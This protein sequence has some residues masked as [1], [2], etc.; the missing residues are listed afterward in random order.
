[1]LK[2]TISPLNDWVLCYTEKETVRVLYD[3]EKNEEFL[4]R[5]SI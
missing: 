2:K 5:L 3:M 4:K 1:M